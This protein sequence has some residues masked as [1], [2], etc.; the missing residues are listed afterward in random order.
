MNR[1]IITLFVCSACLGIY[2]LAAPPSFDERLVN[3]GYTYSFGIAAA[4]I[5]GDGD[6]DLTSA[7]ALPNNKLY[8][9]ENDGRGN[10]KTHVIQK[11]DPERLERH[12]LAD[13]DRDG[14]L[15][16]VIVKNLHGDV[17]WFRNDGTPTDGE[18]WERHVICDKQLAGAYDVAVADFDGDGDL[19]VAASSWRL[20]NNFV[21][22]ENDGT[23]TDGPWKKHVID[24][25]LAETRHIAAEDIDG[26]GDPDLIGTAR[27]ANLVVWYENI[28]KPVENG[29]KR[30]VIDNVSLSPT[31]G[32]CI[33][34]DHDGDLDLV[35]AHGMGYTGDAKKERLIWYENDALKRGKLW[36]VHVVSND[37]LGVFEPTVL[38]YDNDGDHDIAVTIGY[39]DLKIKETPDE[40]HRILLF[41][42]TGDPRSGWKEHVIRK[43]WRRVNMIISTDVNGDGK[44]DLVAGAERGSNEVRTW[45]NTFGK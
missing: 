41:E 15:D 4:D 32:H 35:M 16:L 42:N 45:I 22:F 11:D 3:D 39:G 36:T 29:W 14:H 8:L 1:R 34:L 23:P 25:N 24:E 13:I 33:D 27:E 12:K 37:L 19:D 7:D 21:W 20:S 44:P 2:A 28:G 31:H 38:D 30:R 43:N 5:D 10:F 17:L 26:D 9:H 40:E 6:M 18:L